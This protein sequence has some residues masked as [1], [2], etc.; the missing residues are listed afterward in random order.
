MG[1][2]SRYWKLV[3]LN[4]TGG[5]KV[6]EIQSAK[7]FF[8]QQFSHLVEQ[9]DMPDALLIQR[10][11]VHLLGASS[12]DADSDATSYLAEL[13][14]RCFI[15][16][17]IEQVCIQLENQFGSKHGFTRNELFP[18]VLNDVGETRLHPSRGNQS[19]YKSF[20]TEILQTFDIERS[21]L[22]T[23]TSKLVKNHRELNTFLLE[24]GVYMISDWAIL[25]DT[26][27]K[28]LQ[29]I[30]AEFHNLSK[31]ETQQA[32]ILLESYHAVYRRDRLKQRQTG[33]KGQCLPPTIDQLQQIAQLCQKANCTPSPEVIMSSLQKIA[34]HLR[35][36]RIY[37]RGGKTPTE[38]LDQPE[39]QLVAERL[40]SSSI[41]DDDFDE[42]TQ[43]LTSYRQ[44]F[45]NCLDRAMEQVTSD[46][47]RYL[48]RKDSQKAQQFITALQLFH[49]Q[50]QS[51][52]E[53]APLVGLQAQFQV[54]RLL[55]LKGF[56]ADVRQQMLKTLRVFILEKAKA[57]TDPQHLRNLEQQV[58]V[59]LDEQIANLLH[60]AETEASIAKNRSSTSLFARRLCRYLNIR[61]N[62]L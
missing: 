42:Q 24:H 45:I 17:Q 49:C 46:H 32:A 31:D 28:Q 15:S 19:S 29:R 53:I 14:L 1:A 55:K 35:Q 57:Y 9:T 41:N 52:G 6:E 56:R 5:R 7:A 34:E 58:E 3:R 8:K 30:F 47:F 22:T 43:F 44:Q 61:N 39:T 11:L 54:S 25:N 36:Y 59:A 37:A 62:L 27:P 23:W 13:C 20:A 60:E 4:A 48:Q 33:V 51:M 21:S 10:Q 40:H 16:G 18:F 38:S 26:T 12:N 2:A 50:G